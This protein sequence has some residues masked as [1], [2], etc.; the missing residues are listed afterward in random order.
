MHLFF[1]GETSSSVLTGAIGQAEATS[2]TMTDVEKARFDQDKA[3]DAINLY[4]YLIPEDGNCLFRAVASQ[5]NLDQDKHHP[6]LR[7][8]AAKW[9]REHVDDL[10]ASGLL[11]DVKEI[12]DTEHLGGWAGQAAL[13]AL[14][15]IYGITVSVLHGGDNGNIDLQY[16]T[17]FETVL[18]EH[19]GDV[20]L[21]YLYHGHYDTVV[22]SPNG[23]NPQYDAWI[24][25]RQQ[26]IVASE[27]LACELA[28]PVVHIP[29]V[30]EPSNSH[31]TLPSITDANKVSLDHPPV[32]PTELSPIALTTEAV[33]L[34]EN[35]RPTTI[36]QVFVLNF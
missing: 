24:A 12:V 16:I 20:M 19:Q 18:N 31:G 10:L 6:V 11:D 3:M 22:G 23:P 5:L 4:R 35:S 28:K 21:A 8:K 14:T 36:S 32:T 15:N 25:H 33:D 13:V 17:P 7:Q 29:T 30:S 9:M 1:Q 27:V 26:Q 34:L 2:H